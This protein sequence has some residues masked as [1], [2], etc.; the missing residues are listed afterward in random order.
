M[1]DTGWMIGNED[2][3][4]IAACFNAP[5]GLMD[6][7]TDEAVFAA[8]AKETATTDPAERKQVI[9]DELWPALNNSMSTFPLFDS[10]MIWAYRTELKGFKAYPTSNIQFNELYFE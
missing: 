1:I 10:Y 3:E 6:F 5:H 9:H 4:E 2:N 8:I 7:S